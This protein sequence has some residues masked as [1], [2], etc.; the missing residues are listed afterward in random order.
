[1]WGVDSC[2]AFTQDWWGTTGLLP[3]VI[4]SYGSPDFWGRYLTDTVCPHISADEI[5]TAARDHMGILPIYNDY[6]C[7]NVSSYATGHSYG[8]SAVQAAESLGIPEGRVLAIDIEPPGAAC[9]GAANVDSGFIEGWYDAVFGGGYAPGYY[10]NGTNGSEFGS[11]WCATVGV[12]PNIARDSYLWSFEPSLQGGYTK[13]TAPDYAPYNPG[14]A[15]IAAAW[16]YELSAG[17]DPD[18][19]SDEA[20]S[21]LPL[22]YP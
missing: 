13:S 22:W 9:P 3:Q 15:G 11:A 6:D 16:Q 7:S 5:A 19:D 17:S 12:L 1:L 21:Q 2:K 10:G 14:C 4:A 20:L 8:D 18:V